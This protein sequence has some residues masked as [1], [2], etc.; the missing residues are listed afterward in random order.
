MKTFLGITILILLLI[1]ISKSLALDKKIFTDNDLNSYKYGNGEVKSNITEKNITKDTKEDKDDECKSICKSAEIQWNSYIKATKG[2]RFEDVVKQYQR[3]VGTV[4]TEEPIREL[5]NYG[6]Y[7]YELNGDKALSAEKF[8][9]ITVGRCVDRCSIDPIIS[10]NIMAKYKV[11]KN[12]ECKSICLI[13]LEIRWNSYIK[14]TKGERFEDVVKQYQRE[15]GTVPTEE[16]VRELVGYG[17]N[18][19]RL[20]G[21]KALS[22]EKELYYMKRNGCVDRCSGDFKE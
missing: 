13:S 12:D 17:F 6:F 16:P 5:V 21:D 4:P 10:A 14:A 18:L 7:L 19:Y 8:Y 2:E 1:P 11:D 15:V 3:E 9:E 20:N 22:A